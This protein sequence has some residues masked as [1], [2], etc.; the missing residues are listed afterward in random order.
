MT[1]STRE[2]ILEVAGG[3]FFRQGYRA[4]GIDTIIAASGVAK[5]TLYRHFP[6]K[7]SLIVAYLEQ[8]N[9]AFFAWFEAAVA[10][11]DTPRGQLVAVYAALQKL[12]T[13]PACYG[14]PFLIAAT[15]F[16]EREH[17]GHVVALA[18]KEQVRA[19]LRVLCQGL[20]LAVDEAAALADRLLLLMDAAFMAVR[21][22]G[23]ANPA[24]HVADD[25]RRL[26]DCALSAR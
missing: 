15:E 21:L 23:V 14:C 7:D 18:N 9:T 3:L 1:A 17:P 5:A 16:P 26:L 20:A 24:A 10:T 11:A 22:Y 25:A 6:S 2:H 12:V 13:S 8:V 19:R 4:V